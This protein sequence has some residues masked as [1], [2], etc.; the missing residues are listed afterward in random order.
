MNHPQQGYPQAPSPKRGMG[1]GAI[2]GIVFAVVLVIAVGGIGLVCV[3]IKSSGS[4]AASSASAA[5]RAEAPF[6]A[7]L[8]KLVA[9]PKAIKP[10]K[11]SEDKEDRTTDFEYAK[12]PGSPISEF[13]LSVKKSNAAGWQIT[14]IAP[15]PPVPAED[16]APTGGLSELPKGNPAFDAVYELTSGSLKGAILQSSKTAG[17]VSTLQSA[18]YVAE[19]GGPVLGWLCDNGRVPGVKPMSTTEFK[20]QCK[21]MVEQKLLSPSSA[22]FPGVFDSVPVETTKGCGRAW[23]AWVKAKNAFG[24]EIRRTF[25]CTHDPVKNLVN[26]KM[27]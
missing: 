11:I 23:P 10:T 2:L 7:T 8:A 20:V 18:A 6:V 24:V 15:S 27:D 19:K 13:T 1:A 9:N 12:V 26:L 22:E 16:F 25:T 3:A 21:G 14:W 5:P 17:N 4:K